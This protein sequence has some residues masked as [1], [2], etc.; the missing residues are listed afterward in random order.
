MCRH[1]I[2]RFMSWAAYSSSSSCSL[3][4]HFES[5]SFKLTLIS[6]LRHENHR[7]ILI[8]FSL[9]LDLYL[10]QW[11][12]ENLDVIIAQQNWC[13]RNLRLLILYLFNFT[14]SLFSYSQTQSNWRWILLAHTFSLLIL[15]S[16]FSLPRCIALKSGNGLRFLW[17]D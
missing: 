17:L 16:R 14:S 13:N 4:V 7:K 6:T 11:K 15:T 9:S 2:D 5:T 10:W 3:C 1:R 8:I 12:K